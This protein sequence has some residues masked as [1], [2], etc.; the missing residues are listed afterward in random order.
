MSVCIHRCC[1]SLM[2]EISVIMQILVQLQ[3]LRNEGG[4]D[5]FKSHRYCAR[6]YIRRPF[7][8][9]FNTLILFIT[10]RLSDNA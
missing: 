9:L 10:Y 6:T 3:K 5:D 1:T 2:R 8:L 7:A 4:Q